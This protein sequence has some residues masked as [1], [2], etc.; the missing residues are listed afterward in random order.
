MRTGTGY[1]DSSYFQ[2]ERGFVA[3]SPFGDGTDV[4]LTDASADLLSRYSVVIVS[5]YQSPILHR[6]ESLADV[7]S[8]ASVVAWPEKIP[9]LYQD[10]HTSPCSAL[11]AELSLS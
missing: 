7:E 2:D 3:P 5:R 6:L 1:G 10:V 11:L 9:L 4:L 8:L